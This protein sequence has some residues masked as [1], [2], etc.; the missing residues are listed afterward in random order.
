M[1]VHRGLRQIT[2]NCQNTILKFKSGQRHQC[3]QILLYKGFESIFIV[4][5]FTLRRCEFCLNDTKTAQRRYLTLWNFAKKYDKLH[6]IKNFGYC[7]SRCDFWGIVQM[8][9]T[10]CRIPHSKRAHNNKVGGIRLKL[11]FYQARPKQEISCEEA[12]FQVI[13]NKYEYPWVCQQ[14]TRPRLCTQ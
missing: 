12:V 5:I 7:F 8:T 4:P 2:I 10:I 14:H 6:H 1:A 13:C 11:R 9:V 3:S